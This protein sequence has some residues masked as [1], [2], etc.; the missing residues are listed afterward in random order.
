MKMKKTNRKPTTLVCPYN[1]TLTDDTN[2]YF[3]DSCYADYVTIV[4]HQSRKSMA[5]D[6]R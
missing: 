5:C 3:I 6:I 4:H 1:N 2:S